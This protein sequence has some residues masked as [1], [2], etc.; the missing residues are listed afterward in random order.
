MP[1]IWGNCWRR[2]DRAS[3]EIPRSGMFQPLVKRLRHSQSGRR[4]K[5]NRRRSSNSNLAHPLGAGAFGQGLAALAA[6]VTLTY[7]NFATYYSMNAFDLL[8]WT[9]GAYVI[10]GILKN[11][12]P[13]G[14]LLFGLIA[15]L[16][17]QNKLSMGF[18]GLGLCVALVLTRNRKYIVSKVDGK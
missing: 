16:G 8:F 7:L 17:L 3:E 18:F 15:G 12:A 1:P 4:R 11:D 13:K 5:A 9:L 10:L 2:G 6:V 14:W